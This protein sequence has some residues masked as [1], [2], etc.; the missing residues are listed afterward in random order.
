MKFSLLAT[1]IVAL[2]LAGCGKPHQ[3]N[4]ESIEGYGTITEEGTTVAEERAAA[5]PVS[6]TADPSS[7]EVKNAVQASD[8]VNDAVES[9]EGEATSAV[10]AAGGVTGAAVGA[11]VGAAAGGLTAPAKGLT[12]A[13]KCVDKTGLPILCTAAGA[14][15][16]GASPVE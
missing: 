14:I 11:G 5:G 10:D 3:A 2:A 8:E 16:T 7:F 9:A 6:E 13:L 15:N 12:S 4:P 1:A